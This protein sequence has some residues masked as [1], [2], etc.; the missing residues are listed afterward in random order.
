[1]V[2]FIVGV[3]III[4]LAAGAVGAVLTYQRNL[5]LTVLL[6]EDALRR[7]PP[8]ARQMSLTS[9]HGIIY[10][11][12]IE[13]Y[14]HIKIKAQPA[15]EPASEPASKPASKPVFEGPREPL[16]LPSRR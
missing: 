7:M 11:Q 14:C 16:I 15:S 4:L 1:M 3:A 13:T 10:L 8:G 2:K 12:H 5:A 9:L 6:C